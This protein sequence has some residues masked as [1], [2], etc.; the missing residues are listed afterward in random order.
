VGGELCLFPG[1]KSGATG[2]QSWCFGKVQR[3]F[4]GAQDD[5]AVL[6]LALCSGQA[7]RGVGGELLSNG[8]PFAIRLEGR[9]LRCLARGQALKACPD[10]NPAEI[11]QFLEPKPGSG[12]VVRDA[13]LKG[14]SSTVDQQ[15]LWVRKLQIPRFPRN[16]QLRGGSIAS[17]ISENEMWGTPGVVGR[18]KIKI[19][20]RQSEVA[21][22]RGV[23]G[24][25]CLPR[26]Y[27]RGFPVPP[28]WGCWVGEG[29]PDC[30]REVI[31][32]LTDFR[33]DEL[34]SGGAP[35]GAWGRKGV[36]NGTPF[37]IRLEGRL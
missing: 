16:D 4:A 27:V 9:L 17:H 3:S 28:L 20:G 8:A 11:S 35:C 2:L 13:A 1:L 31:V 26:T 29:E 21:P 25:V 24:F 33:I 19:A 22:W 5:N 15:L 10:T 30:R 7:L 23:G 32:G 37:A 6:A 36:V 34:R 18:A 12:W 14:R